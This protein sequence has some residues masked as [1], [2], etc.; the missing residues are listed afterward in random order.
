MGSQI[1]LSFSWLALFVFTET[2]PPAPNQR[3][4][5][6][7]NGGSSQQ[8][9]LGKRHHLVF[10]I[11]CPK[12][13]WTAPGVRVLLPLKWLLSQEGPHGLLPLSCLNPCSFLSRNHGQTKFCFAFR[14]NRTGPVRKRS[15]ETG[16]KEFLGGVHTKE[17]YSHNLHSNRNT[18]CDHWPIGYA[19][20]EGL[21]SLAVCQCQDLQ[22]STDWLYHP[23][24]AWRD[25]AAD[26]Q[27]SS[28]VKSSV[29]RE[30]PLPPSVI[31]QPFCDC[32]S[33]FFQ[34]LFFLSM[35]SIPI[36]YV[37]D[38]C[39]HPMLLLNTQLSF[40]LPK[41]TFLLVILGVTN[42]SKWSS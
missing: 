15:V 2:P 17:H 13:L 21:D 5:N 32:C 20:S 16:R 8:T 18:S 33:P 41:R 10:R 26:G 36:L 1:F 38:I 22:L 37:Y 6:D 27:G 14:K 34:V 3:T 42:Q 23:S 35:C 24:V 25:R 40:L 31:N 7:S 11:T 12:L 28:S 29:V 4:H 30:A 39:L 9:I 19:G